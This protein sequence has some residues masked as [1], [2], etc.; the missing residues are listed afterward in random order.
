M[1]YSLPSSVAESIVFP[2]E[3]TVGGML[4]SLPISVTLRRGTFWDS[5]LELEHNLFGDAVF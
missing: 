2:V 5:V 4:F 3:Q 1:N